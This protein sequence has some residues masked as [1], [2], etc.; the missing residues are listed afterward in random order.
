MYCSSFFILHCNCRSALDCSD[1]LETRI[2][3][4]IEKLMSQK[5][6][7]EERFVDVCFSILSR[8][9]F[10][11][12]CRLSLLLCFSKCCFSI[13]SDS[14]SFLSFRKTIREQLNSVVQL[15]L[16]YV[17]D[18]EHLFKLAKTV[19]DRPRKEVEVVFK[20]GEQC[21]RSIKKVRFSPLPLSSLLSQY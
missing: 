5:Q 7:D 17:K 21:H 19:S 12:L 6:I 16:H 4:D 10:L 20:F 3:N 18:P 2:E 8:V 14:Y 1:D 15:C 13:T 9:V 11:C